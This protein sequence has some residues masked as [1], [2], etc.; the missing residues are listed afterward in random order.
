MKGLNSMDIIG[1]YKITNK[2]TGKCYIGESINIT[3]RWNR[4]LKELISNTHHSYKLQKAFNEY[5]IKNFNF[6]I[7]EILNSYN[8]T[9]I[10]KIEK[11]YIDSYNSIENGYN[12][13]DSIQRQEIYKRD[14]KDKKLQLQNGNKRNVTHIEDSAEERLFNLANKYEFKEEY[15]KFSSVLQSIGFNVPNTY[16]LFRDIGFF[17]I[18]NH[19]QNDN[20]KLFKLIFRI[21]TNKITGQQYEGYTSYLTK[22]G[23]LFVVNLLI[24]N[25]S[26]SEYNIFTKRLYDEIYCKS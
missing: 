1:I 15:E 26:K 14:K 22:E 24:E 25:L 20:I 5:G 4:H 9:E 7:L 23:L 13:D 12:V 10:L 11:E 3:S 21:T 18:S 16:H 2:I 19:V 8:K 17:N 6:E